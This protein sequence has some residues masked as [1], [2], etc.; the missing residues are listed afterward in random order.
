[1]EIKTNEYRKLGKTGLTTSPFALGCWAFGGPPDYP[2]QDDKESIKTIRTAIDMGINVFDTAE[3]YGSGH[4]EE[5]LGEAVRQ[6]GK[7]V[8]VITKVVTWSHD[9]INFRVD[10]AHVRKS[11]EGSLRRLKTDC[12]DI[13]MFHWPSS[14]IIMDEAMHTLTKMKSEGKIKVLG[15]SNFQLDELQNVMKYGEIEIVQSPYSLLWRCLEDDLFPYCHENGISIIT[16]SPLANGLLTNAFIDNGMKPK[17][18]TQNWLV[19]FKEPYL[20]LLRPV[21]QELEEIAKRY[22]CTVS[23]ASLS[24]VLSK[25]IS[26]C[27]LGIEKIDQFDENIKALKINLS[28]E[29]IAMLDE[30]GRPLKEEVA[31]THKRSMTG[32][33]PN[34]DKSI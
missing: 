3:L 17:S 25:K 19:L 32:W 4:S 34:R 10:A 23:Q 9:D 7:D 11:V 24:W 28:A 5:I 31:S 13:Y 1:M 26:A 16:Y 2:L 21:L 8:V 6:S 27:L 14:D 30:A 12:L 22:G 29:D 18:D 33:W 15:V 20:S